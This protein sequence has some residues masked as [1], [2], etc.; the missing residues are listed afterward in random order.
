MQRRSELITGGF[1]DGGY[2][3]ITSRE[4]L[5]SWRL[6]QVEVAWQVTAAMNVL[7]IRQKT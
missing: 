4:L 6:E 7:T 2:A 1:P 3:D 5:L